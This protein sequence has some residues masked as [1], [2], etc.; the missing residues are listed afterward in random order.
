MSVI[1][2]AS[3]EAAG[4]R[5]APSTDLPI[6]REYWLAHCEGYRVES[7]GGRVGLVEEVHRDADGERA[8][9]LAVLAGMLGRRRII[10]PVS[11]VDA[12]IPHAER[13]LLKTAATIVGSEPRSAS[14]D[15]DASE[16]QPRSARTR[17]T[18]SAGGLRPGPV[19]VAE[20]E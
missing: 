7:A 4:S 16:I 3:S 17:A 19:D 1:E 9:S 10:I 20:H 5:S 14:S 2:A 11:E 8:E 18:S 13:V 15:D 6:D 12:V